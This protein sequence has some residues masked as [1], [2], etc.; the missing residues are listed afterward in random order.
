M[1]ATA[2]F[3][4]YVISML[5]DRTGEFPLHLKGI[6]LEFQPAYCVCCMEGE[7]NAVGNSKRDNAHY[8]GKTSYSGYNSNSEKFQLLQILISY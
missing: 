2:T 6:Y 5:M 4:D 8:E 7:G 3:A 1:I